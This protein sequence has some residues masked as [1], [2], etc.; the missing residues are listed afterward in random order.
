V[1][2]VPPA[3]PDGWAGVIVGTDGSADSAIAVE[4]AAL[5]AHRLRQAL[6]VVHT[7]EGHDAPSAVGSEG[8]TGKPPAGCGVLS[9]AVAGVARNYPD[10]NVHPVLDTGRSPAE[11]LLRAGE[12]ALLLV[13]GCRGRGGLNALVGSVAREV[14]LGSKRPTLITRSSAGENSVLA[15][16]AYTAEKVMKNQNGQI[17]GGNSGGNDQRPVQ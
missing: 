7:C 8:S 6:T 15:A 17:T 9:A 5:E 13:I 3:G 4:R 16:T 12:N 14:L 11:A 10:L 1:A 2:V